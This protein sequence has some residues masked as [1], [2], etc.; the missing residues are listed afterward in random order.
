MA[1]QRRFEMGL[2]REEFF[3][4][5]PAAVGSFE[6]D[7][8]AAHWSDGERAWT[9]QLLPLPDRRLGSVTV[10]RCQVDLSLHGYADDE[11]AA[12]ITRFERAFM[13]GGG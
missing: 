8:H 13:R 5:L 12:F 6:A 9:I 4:T 3:R 1:F 10:P 7:D 2:S 11:A